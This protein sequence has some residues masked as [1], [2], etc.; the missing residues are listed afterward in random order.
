MK[1]ILAFDYGASGG[2]AILGSY[3]GSGLTLKEIHRFSNDPVMVGGTL[4]WDVLR[5]YHELKQGILKGYQE[6]QGNISSIGI[7]TWGVDFGLLDNNDVL[8]GNPVHYR[9]G[10]T[11]GMIEEALKAVTKEEIYKNT[12]I[13]FQKFNTIYQLLSMVK[14]R[15]TILERAETL[16]FM[17]DLFK[18]FLT[19]EKSCEFTIASTSQMLQSGRATWAYDLLNTLGIPVQILPELIDAGSFVGVLQKSVQDEL[20]VG[21]IPV[22]AAASHDTASAVIAAPISGNDEAYISSGTWSLLGIECEKPVISETT[23]NHNY[24]NE[25]GFNRTV[26]L[27]KN[28]MGLWVYQEC[29]RAW[30]KEGY[31]LSYDKMDALA[32]E[33]KPFQAFID[34]DDEPFYSP[35]NM[36]A[37][38]IDYCG[39][40]NQQIPEDMGSIIRIVIESLALKYRSS[41][42]ELEKIINKDI[43]FLRIVGGGCRNKIL[44]QYTA[45][46]LN[47]P[48][49][50]GPVEA[51]AIGNIISQL[52]ALK[53]L[54]DIQQAREL[55]SRSFP[56][57]EYQ[58]ENTGLWNEAYDRFKKILQAN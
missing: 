6:T 27:L 38:V 53:E 48:V 51:T 18:F 16:L 54:E 22:I 40:T 10:R 44:C 29:R 41:V 36:P 52:L 5:L 1:H 24:T 17:P 12:G 19:G 58:P 13:A 25:G 26:R 31:S 2:R 42:E 7:D 11:D 28:I 4:Y 20:G 33:A 34:V 15:S 35:G 43:S 30:Q 49:T 8:L 45:N 32:G 57:E 56:K 14:K 46:V 55:V 47:R 3:D 21:E 37:K 39:R 50:A 23:L 9:D